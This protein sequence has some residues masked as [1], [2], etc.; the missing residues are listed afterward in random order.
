MPVDIMC[1]RRPARLENKPRRDNNA[2]VRRPPPH[3]SVGNV[4]VVID[5]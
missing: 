1:V 5:F 2:R 4:L 3:R